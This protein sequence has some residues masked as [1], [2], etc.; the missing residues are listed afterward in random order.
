M[1]YLS[2]ETGDGYYNQ[3]AEE[4]AREARELLE[5]TVEDEYHQRLTVARVA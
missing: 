5:K 1:P 4:R 2:P 3:P